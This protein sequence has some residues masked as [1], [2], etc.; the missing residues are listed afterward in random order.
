MYQSAL[1]KFV[2]GCW[3]I[4]GNYEFRSTNVP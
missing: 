2:G 4:H 3:S 1:D